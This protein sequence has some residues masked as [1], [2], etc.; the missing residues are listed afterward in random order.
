MA[1]K[2]QALNPQ[3]RKLHGVYG[4]NVI[5]QDDGK[6]KGAKEQNMRRPNVKYYLS[7]LQDPVK[8]TEL[9]RAGCAGWPCHEGY[10][11]NFCL[12]R[13]EWTAEA[14]LVPLQEEVSALRETVA[15]LRQQ[16][17][18][19]ETLDKAERLVASKHWSAAEESRLGTLG[20]ML[21]DSKARLEAQEA[22]R[23]QQACET[24]RDTLLAQLG[25]IQAGGEQK[26][27][28]N[29]EIK[30][31]VEG[32]SEAL[33]DTQ[34]QLRFVER[35]LDDKR[36]TIGDA[37]KEKGRAGHEVRRQKTLLEA[38]NTEL[39]LRGEQVKALIVELQRRQDVEKERDHFKDVASQRA[40][41]AHSIM[42]EV[43]ED[44]VLAE[45]TRDEH[46][47]AMRKVAKENTL[48]KKQLMAQNNALAKVR[49]ELMET[50]A[51]LKAFEEE[52]HEHAGSARQTG[53]HRR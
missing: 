48:V 22:K 33:A 20:S 49:T 52:E 25:A 44:V 18:D 13:P 9:R 47:S 6:E 12:L 1:Q 40:R 31:R 5:P 53:H 29:S 46:V 34:R 37:I 35:E 19:V 11:C 3:D 32:L 23:A 42:L 41:L 45:R 24:V 17:A 30:Q 38:Q 43:S 27:R 36:S 28:E 8:V 7:Q 39:A 51:H 4:D 14:K 50:R 16:Q 10:L 26:Q 2:L 15:L 21:E